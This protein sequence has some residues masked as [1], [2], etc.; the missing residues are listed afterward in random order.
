[1]TAAAGLPAAPQ[2]VVVGL[3]PSASGVFG[4]Q[5]RTTKGNTLRTREMRL[6]QQFTQEVKTRVDQYFKRNRL[7]KH[8]DA[9]MV[10]KTVCLLV[11]YFGSFGLIL[12][13][14]PPLPW[15]WFLCL[16]MGVAMA[17]IGFSV[18]HDAL[19]GAYSS[20]RHVNRLIGYVFDGLGANGYM[21]KI[22]HNTIHHTYTNIRGCDEDLEVSPLIRLSP[23]TPYRPIHCFQH[24][25]AFFAYALA[26]VFWVFVKDYKYFFQKDLGP[27]HDKKH[28]RWEWIFLIL[29]K[30]LYYLAM[31][32]LPL[33][34]LDV[35]WW[36]FLIGFLTMHMTAGLI[37]GVVFQLAHVVE[38]TEHLDEDRAGT[39][40]G[41]WTLHQMRTTNNFARDNRL[42]SW[43]VGGLNF[44]IEHHLFPRICHVHY[45]NLS[46]IVQ[47]LAIKYGIPYNICPTLRDVIRSHYRMLKEFGRPVGIVDL[48]TARAV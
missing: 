24:A 44:Q 40:K 8:A 36:Q 11:V 16:V 29:S 28:P 1:M 34:V 14:L 5:D 32:V 13:G 18:A 19:H 35:T 4:L 6:N 48:A 45:R 47:E 21:W 38:A 7:S 3:P 20:N 15:A 22:T 39:L 41:V 31:I 33:L 25:F 9:A 2:R 30:A 46:P 27:Y 12:T 17:G 43:Y 10:A 23:H 26:T 42:L 37:L